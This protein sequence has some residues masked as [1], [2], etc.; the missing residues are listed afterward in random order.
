MK[1]ILKIFILFYIAF[2][3]LQP[4]VIRVPN[5]RF[6]TIQDAIDFAFEGDTLI[7]KNGT[8]KESLFFYGISLVLSSEYLFSG[9]KNDIQNIR[10]RNR[11]ICDIA[12]IS[13][14]V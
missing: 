8:Y 3:F 2:N 1:I 12:V 13:C 5:E 7:V 9:N 14:W 10:L 6:Q 4:E 11:H